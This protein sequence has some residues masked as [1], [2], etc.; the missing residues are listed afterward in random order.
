MPSYSTQ[1]PETLEESATPEV[2]S[3]EPLLEAAR[4]D[5]EA[6]RSASVEPHSYEDFEQFLELPGIGPAEIL[7][8]ASEVWRNRSET[9]TMVLGDAGLRGRLQGLMDSESFGMLLVYWQVGT[10]NSFYWMHDAVRWLDGAG[11][12]THSSWARLIAG[13]TASQCREVIENPAALAIVR[14]S[15][16]GN[17]TSLFPELERDLFQLDHVLSAVPEFKAWI[18]DVGGV[19]LLHQIEGEIATAQEAKT[20]RAEMVAAGTWDQYLS[21]LPDG[22]IGD[23]V[24][25]DRLYFYLLCEDQVVRQ[26]LLYRKRFG[27]DLVAGAAKP[28]SWLVE[29]GDTLWGIADWMFG[30][31]KRWKEIYEFGGNQSKI[32]EDP[33]L[34]EPG[35]DLEVPNDPFAWDSESIIRT[36]TVSHMLPPADVAA[37]LTIIRE[38]SS[39][40][41]SGWASSDGEMG[42]SWGTGLLNATEIGSYTSDDDPMRGLNIYDATLR[43]EIG[44]HV[45]GT[46]GLDEVGSWTGEFGWEEYSDTKSLR[47]VF[48]TFHT[49][50]PLDLSGLDIRD[51][52]KT[53]RRVFRALA[54]LGSW[55]EAT[56]AAAVNG[57]QDGLF[58]QVQD[59]AFFSFFFSRV[60]GWAEP[61]Y[62]NGRS[63]HA[64]YVDW[65]LFQSVPAQTYSKKVST[66]AMRSSG[67]WF[68]EIYAT[69]YSDADRPGIPPGTLLESRDPAAAAGFRDRVHGRHTLAG[70][71]G[72]V[73]GECAP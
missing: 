1:N 26:V 46:T 67:E 37:T 13:K 9:V 64:P 45:G 35:M 61:E 33:H 7:S 66:Y 6:E 40:E 56:V 17:P 63:Y 72:Q 12:V 31:G 70:Q 22:P 34:I 42:L 15:L 50:H 41:A 52:E 4:G 58:D 3:V 16:A 8:K 27:I 49:V 19:E 48:E 28:G 59:T 60:E 43:H 29:A 2:A 36:W 25:Q 11:G 5:S 30:D 55:E 23:P 47:G 69:F 51:E 18:V 24:E 20:R 32:G 68:A 21:E 44:H 10:D 57:V 38:A 39:G 65:R 14:S 73:Q 71:T 62:I 54:R 53:R